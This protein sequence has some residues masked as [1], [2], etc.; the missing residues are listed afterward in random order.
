MPLT[1]CTDC[2]YRVSD[3]AALCVNCG[4][5]MKAA[6]TSYTEKMSELHFQSLKVWIHL[7]AAVLIVYFAFRFYE[8]IFDK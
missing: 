4:R 6:K 7:G 2:H 5:P 1:A 8:Y 3:S